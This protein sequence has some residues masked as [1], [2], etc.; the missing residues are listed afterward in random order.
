MYIVLNAIA[1]ESIFSFS[2]SVI[3]NNESLRIM[4]QYLESDII[5]FPWCIKHT[6]PV[7]YYFCLCSDANTRCSF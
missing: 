6:L 5:D 1:N 3:F 4:Q 2:L 7:F